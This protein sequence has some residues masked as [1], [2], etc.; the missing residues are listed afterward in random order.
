MFIGKALATSRAIIQ[1]PLHYRALQMAIN[2]VTPESNPESNLL[3]CLD[4]YESRIPLN[5]SGSQLVVNPGQANDD[6]TY[7]SPQLV[8]I[9]ESDAS[10]LGVEHVVATPAQE[11][12]G[13]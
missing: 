11:G 10:N 3:G 9:I 1:A 6:L 4:K 2:T 12:A 8:L 7:M 5:S 13:Q